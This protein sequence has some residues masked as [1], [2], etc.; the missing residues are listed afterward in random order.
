[1]RNISQAYLPLVDNLCLSNYESIIFPNNDDEDVSETQF[2]NEPNVNNREAVTPTQSPIN[3]ACDIPNEAFDHAN[4][5]ENVVS[6]DNV[7]GINNYQLSMPT[8][9]TPPPWL[10]EAMMN[11]NKHNVSSTNEER[12]AM[13][14]Q[15]LY[16]AFNDKC[17]II[18]I[19]LLN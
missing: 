10:V 19:I 14:S 3:L 1:M 9:V 11:N 17:I 6:N 5:N 13:P 4:D 2:S 12:M 16:V 15:S 8:Q 18:N 7:I